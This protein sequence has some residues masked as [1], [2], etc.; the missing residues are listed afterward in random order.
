MIVD[1]SALMAII[2]DEPERTSFV[3]FLIDAGTSK[4][5]AGTWI[6]LA[7]VISRRPDHQELFPLLYGIVERLRV[8]TAA[9]TDRKSVV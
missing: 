2:L 9:M 4:M 6:E 1:S 7:A 5:A 8:S 3:D